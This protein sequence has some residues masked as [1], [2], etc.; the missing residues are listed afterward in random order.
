MSNKP[1]VKADIYWILL[2]LSVVLLMLIPEQ[3][4]WVDTR[5]GWYTQ[6]MMGSLLGLGI[7]AIFSAF[8]VI[9]LSRGDGNVWRSTVFRQNPLDSLVA[10]LDSYRTALISSV[11]FYLYIKSLSII[12][13]VPATFI[14]VTVL[15]WLSRLFNRTW[16][17]ATIATLIALVLIFRVAVSVWLPD[18]WLYSLLPDHLADFANRYL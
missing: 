3:A 5:R 16:V 6:P 2:I 1:L 17:L 11:L 14:F 13:F 8:R 10:I 4:A 7:L 15:L 12:G 9:Q 18:V